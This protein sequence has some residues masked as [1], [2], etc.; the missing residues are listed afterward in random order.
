MISTRVFLPWFGALLIGLPSTPSRVHAQQVPPPAQAQQM[1]QNN[2]ALIARLQQ[3]MQTSGLTPDQVRDRLR[4]QGYPE[5]LLDQYLPGTTRGDSTAA[6]GEDVFAAVRALGI[7][8]PTTIDSLSR[9][10]RG[11]RR[12]QVQ[13][14]SAFRDTVQVALADNST[15]AAIRM[16]LRSREGQRAIAD[17]G[18]NVFGEELFQEGVT[19]FDPT[20]AGGGADPNYRFGPGDQLVLVLTGDVESS[21]PL[22][23]TR[24]GFVVIPKVGVVPV[25]GLTRAQF[26]DVLYRQ[27]G[28]SYSGVRR[29]G[30]TTHFYVNVSQIGQNQVFVQGDVKHPNAYRVSRAGT[31]MTALYAAGGPTSSGSMRNVQVKRN[32]QLVGQLDLYDYAL[33]GDASHDVRLENGDIVFVPPRGPQVRVA[34]QVLRPATYEVKPK[35]TL[36]G[37]LEMAGGFN[38][39]ADRRRVQIE[40]IAPPAERRS[41]G[42]DRKVIDVPSE[43]IPTA[44]VEPGDLVRVL[45]IANRVSSR[46]NVV[47]NVWSPGAV[48]FTPG[49]H[50]YDALR[51]VGGLKPDSYLEQVLVARLQPDSTRRALR[52]AVF[53]TTGRTVGEFDLADGDEITVY[54]I[55]SFR[56]HRY[57]TISGAVGRSGRINFRDRMTLR[58]AILEAQ[59]LSE[60]ALLSEAEIARLPENRAPGVT[61]VTQSV[62]LDSTYLFDRGP[63]GR[64][65]GPPGLAAPTATAPE[66][67][68]RAYD[69]ILIKRQPGWQLQRTV[70]LQGE[71]KYPG[72][73]TL[74]SKSERLSDLIARAGGLTSSAYPEGISFIRYRDGIGR[75]GISLAAVLQDPKHADNLLLADGDS[76]SIPPY[77]AVVT[78]RGAV[79]APTGVA[80]VA[81]ANIDYYIR[82]AGGETIK[83]DFDRA[84]VT[85]PGGKLESKHRSHLFWT[86]KPSPQPG[87]AVFVPERDLTAHHDWA[88]IATTA[89]SILG[90]LVTI[91]ILVRR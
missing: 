64:Y 82:A 85:Q 84:F 26:D 37:V 59:G 86:S 48:A 13:S 10:D 12:A 51:R 88:Q 31:A 60:G 58:D 77:A 69:A 73:Y 68:L 45:E 5:S 18:F 75:V 7:A 19:L 32:G 47:G 52:T 27:L 46:V 53:D 40:R 90:S 22:T 89:T 28:R 2:P 61:A 62:P 81:G 33:S 74:T 36:A 30:G 70:S 39:T 1:L 38:E 42:T 25:A 8:D 6:P 50:L 67:L 80:Y 35:Q 87:A 78:V 3:M 66:I 49:M 17:S 43:L 9:L 29:I 57:I 34:G 71:V 76:I 20:V 63:N 41:S 72:P 21:Y 91:V 23:V 14:D 83:G 16:V 24:D 54:S 56:P 55:T 65:L 11:R 44:L 4:A 15:R 79:N